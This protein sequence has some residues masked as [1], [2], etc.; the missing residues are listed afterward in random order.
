MLHC[1]F[2]ICECDASDIDNCV[3]ML[4]N[5]FFWP[6]LAYCLKGDWEALPAPVY[7]AI[8]TRIIL[9]PGEVHFM[10]L[11]KSHSCHV[12]SSLVRRRYISK[13]VLIIELIRF[14]FLLA[15]QTVL[16]I[17]YILFICF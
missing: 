7:T 6:F 5:P 8:A 11:V 1:T 2:Y 14:V 3:T 13:Y 15:W 17:A 10:H 12:P 9:Y 4:F 16:S